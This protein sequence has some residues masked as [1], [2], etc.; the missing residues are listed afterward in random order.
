MEENS[1]TL[2]K[3][4][5]YTYT[6]DRL[7][8]CLA[9][10]T[11]GSMTGQPINELN[12]AVQ[13]FFEE[14]RNDETLVKCAELAVVTFGDVAQ[15]ALDFAPISEQKAPTLIAGGGTPMGAAVTLALDI[16]NKRK[17][18]LSDA[19]CTYIQPWLVLMSDGAPTDDIKKSA[20]KAC[21]LVMA[22]QLTVMAVAIG[23][24]ADS[25]VLAKF[26]PKFPV[27]MLKGL[28]F[29]EFFE[30][31]KQSAKSSSK[32]ASGQP[33]PLNVNSTWGVILPK[34]NTESEV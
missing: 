21:E 33:V 22:K 11:S 24:S 14:A 5:L 16:A 30:F 27:L 23:P 2:N 7:P 8:I 31:L 17:E 25:E 9:L 29:A 3:E 34:P 26:S 19:G 20:N 32:A 13:Q 4:K 18:F 10:D 12:R 1:L 15:V 6:G 28:K